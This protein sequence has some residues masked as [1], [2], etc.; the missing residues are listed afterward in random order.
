[1]PVITFDYQD[2]KQLFQQD[3]S[4]EELIKRLPMIGADLDKVEDDAI[5]IE[6]FPD[7]PDL[8]SVEGIVR[9][10][11]AFFDIKTGITSYPV[12]PSDIIVKVDA[13]VKDIRPIV[14]CALVKNVTM[15][16]ELITS[17]MDLQEKLHFGV[18][19]NRKKVAIGV[20]N[21]E[22][23]QGP[24]TYKA[25]DPQSVQFVPLGKVESMTL[26]DI[27]EHH[28]K[29]VAYAHLLE[30][31][32][33][34]PLITDTY[35]NVLSFPP[36]INGTLTEV[37][38]FT[39][40]L[41]IDVTGTSLKA[42]KIALNIVTTA[43]AERGGAIFS[44]T[45]INDAEKIVSP[46]LSPSHKPLSIEYVNKILGTNFD[47]N[48]VKKTLEKMGY[49][50]EE[51]EPGKL[52]VFIPAWRP[53]ILHEIDLVEDVAIGYGYDNF[54]KTLPEVFTFGK[55]L[56]NQS[57]R[58]NLRTIMIGFGFNEV[59][60]F[61][62]SNEKD[63]FEKLGMDK[64]TRVELLN[65]ITEDYT[66]IRTSL[67]PSLLKILNE[68]KHHHL[69]QQIFELGI[70]VNEEFKNKFHLG[71]V[72]TSA[73]AHFTECKSLVEGVMREIGISSYEIVEKRHPAFVQGRCASVKKDDKEIGYFG[74]LYPKTILNFEL[75]HPTIAFEIHVDT[76]QK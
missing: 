11:R 60:T 55:Q 61:T 52:T 74:E 18:G 26:K 24:F 19:R 45:I 72:K 34:Y 23:V 50:V 32:T 71:A 21:F 76:L 4:K 62:I 73:K 15:S 69:P 30:D 42:V 59:T 35:D 64:E 6:F 70:V 65:P 58:D 16:D 47:S 9:A 68:N 40:D 49:D 25:V 46:D 2:F 12:Q 8:F 27:L 66:S 31:T 14:R 57:I 5:S 20:H 67:L 33:L 54:K 1:M 38:P 53:D 56:P 75:E 36:I 28:E 29:G 51:K 10:S 44:T 7:R 37:T 3:I 41:F 13:S 17:L 39:T 48:Q 22:P 63:E 43:L